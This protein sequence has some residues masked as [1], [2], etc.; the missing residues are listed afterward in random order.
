MTLIER[1]AYLAQGM[2]GIVVALALI[3][4]TVSQCGRSTRPPCCSRRLCDLFLPLAIVSIRATLSQLQRAL[5]DAGRSL[6][7]SRAA[8]IA[9]IVLPQAAPG[10][11]AAAAIVFVSVETELTATLLLAPIG[12]HTAGDGNLGRHLDDG[13]CVG[14][15]LCWAD[16]AFIAR[17]DL[18]AGAA[19]RPGRRWSCRTRRKSVP[20]ACCGKVDRLF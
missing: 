16:G 7:L 2:P 3:A 9:R 5:E 4:V 15:T 8:V 13:F 1:A 10:I 18:A 19:L 11:G 17:L 6:G 14:C 12:T 20:R